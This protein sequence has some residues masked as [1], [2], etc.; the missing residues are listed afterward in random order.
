MICISNFDAWVHIMV[1][2]FLEPAEFNLIGSQHSKKV[3]ILLKKTI[4]D[5]ITCTM[6]NDFT[7]N[8][9]ILD[10]AQDLL[11]NRMQILVNLVNKNKNL[12]FYAAGDFLQTL[13]TEQNISSSSPELDLSTIDAHSMNIFKRIPGYQYFK[14][15]KCMRSPKAHIDFNNLIMQDIQ[16]KY[17]I[18]TMKASNED[19][20]NKP[21]I[22]THLATSTINTNAKVN[23]DSV[24]GMIEILMTHDQSLVPDDIVIIMGKSNDNDIYTHLRGSLGELFEQMGKGTRDSAVV[25]ATAG[26]G[27]RY[28]LDWEN[29]RG[30]AKMLSIH[31]DKG[32]G[33]KVVFFLGCTEMSIPRQ[34]HV[35]KPAEIISESLLNVGLTRSTKYLF[36][37]FTHSFPSRYLQKHKDK[38]KDHAYIGWGDSSTDKDQIPEP[39]NKIIKFLEE[40]NSPN[41]TKEY[42]DKPTLTGNKSNLQ[43]K[44]DIS[45]DF[46][47]AEDFV[48]HDW[49]ENAEKIVFG[50]KQFIHV[51][52]KED[53]FIILGIMSEILIQRI[54][55]KDKLFKVLNQRNIIY[56]NCEKF[57]CNMYDVREFST[58]ELEEFFNKFQKFFNSAENRRLNLKVKVSDAVRDKSLAVHQIFGSKR[59]RADLAE[60]L[61]EK[62]NNELGCE[63][64]WN[65]ALFYNQMV[66]LW[67]KPVVNTLFGYFNQDLTQLH[68]NIEKFVKLFL[69][70]HDDILCEKSLQ[71]KS[72]FTPNQCKEL[73]LKQD[74]HFVSISGRLDIYNRDTGELFEIKASGLDLC[75]QEWI[76]Q[77]LCYASLLDIEK[78]EVKNLYIVNVLQGCIWKWDMGKIDLPD[79]E[80][81]IESKIKQ[82]YNWHEME[83]DGLVQKVREERDRLLNMAK[84]RKLD[85]QDSLDS[86]IIV[87]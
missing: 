40:T 27:K 50:T 63:C 81:I 36:L 6:K 69:S 28:N 9:I 62:S 14:L 38:L 74:K 61:S 37:G 64:I 2:K 34:S 49:D 35:F 47:R 5:T 30:K 52:F 10:E 78:I 32:K 7:P 15:T 26:D 18:E 4:N 25:M 16:L 17:N 66:Q 68:L 60:F 33:H 53:H 45:K 44:D 39:Y 20:I 21:L 76:I 42:Q 59:F 31:G 58:E 11:S 86:Q 22:F 3:N 83:A 87:E 71:I 19:T 12:D 24:T 75:S 29:A 85:Y 46:E 54:I 55:S 48:D 65:V 80:E 8:L 1:E 82:R 67:Y 73:N 51:P 77:T 72:T 13:Y 41:W 56:S 70:D 43:C 84:R 79:I 57:L 23:A